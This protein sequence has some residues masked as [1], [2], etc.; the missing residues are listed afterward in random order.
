MDS[1]KEIKTKYT[2]AK[3]FGTQSD[4][5]MHGDSCYAAV[6]YFRNW[7][8]IE[9]VKNDIIDDNLRFEWVTGKKRIGCYDIQRTQLPVGDCT[10]YLS[11]SIDTN[12]GL[13][14][15]IRLTAVGNWTILADSCEF[16][17]ID[18]GGVGKKTEYTIDLDMKPGRIGMFM[19]ARGFGTL[20]YRGQELEDNY[21]SYVFKDDKVYCLA[22][23]H[24][25]A[26]WD[27]IDSDIAIETYTDI[28]GEAC[29]KLTE[30]LGEPEKRGRLRS[31]TVHTTDDWC[32]GV[33]RNKN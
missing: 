6:D 10:L 30:I 5:I 20:R 33:R 4:V 3:L 27:I 18:R 2:R 23:R 11:D 21:N 14:D 1:S 15:M 24:I 25:K 29:E 12:K 16:S 9:F 17:L 19:G 26:Y 28:D 7:F 22:Y 8:N 32:L 31:W 13:S